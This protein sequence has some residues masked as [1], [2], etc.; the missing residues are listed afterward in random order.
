MKQLAFCS[1]TETVMGSWY[2]IVVSIVIV[3]YVS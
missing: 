2:A 1:C 3:N